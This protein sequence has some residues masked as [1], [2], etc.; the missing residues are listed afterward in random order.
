MYGVDTR[1]YK[2]VAEYAQL[3]G[4]LPGFKSRLCGFLAVWP[5][6]SYTTSL[7]VSFLTSEMGSAPALATPSHP[8]SSKGPL[9]LH[10]STFLFSSSSSSFSVSTLVAV[11]VWL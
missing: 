4:W 7:G 3:G 2:I 5:W 8:G 6:V 9:T 10:C 11:A 1:G